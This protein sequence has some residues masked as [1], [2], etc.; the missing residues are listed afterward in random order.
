MFEKREQA[1]WL[2]HLDV[3]R[4]FERAVRMSEL[5]VEYSQGFNPRPRISF[6]SALPLGATGEAEIV[7]IRLRTK[8]SPRFV[9]EL[10]NSHLPSGIR[11]VSTTVKKGGHKVPPVSASEYLVTIDMPTGATTEDARRATEQLLAQSRIDYARESGGKRR[12]I[13][14]RSGIESLAVLPDSR[15]NVAVLQM[16]LPQ[17]EFAVKP[18]EVVQALSSFLSGIRIRSIHRKRLIITE[19]GNYARKDSRSPNSYQQ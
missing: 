6:P 13:D 18:S 19:H 5:D 2:G 12:T 1:K 7:I 11:I 9:T 8:I 4:A 15:S 14:L 3:A 17:R 10:I 16:V